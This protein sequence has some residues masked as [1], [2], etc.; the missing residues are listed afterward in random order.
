M[1]DSIGSCQKSVL[2]APISNYTQSHG[3]TCDGED[4]CHQADTK[5]YSGI[6]P[7]ADASDQCLEDK[8]VGAA[9]RQDCQRNNRSDEERDIKNTA[10][11]L[12]G[13]QQLP[14]VEI[15]H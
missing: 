9:L 10:E 4:D 1:E 3:L 7:T 13:I 15:E 5:R 2:S 11:R 8:V 12:K 6:S 14:E